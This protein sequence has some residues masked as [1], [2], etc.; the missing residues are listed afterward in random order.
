M[1]VFLQGIFIFLYYQHSSAESSIITVVLLL[2]LIP[3]CSL[4]LYCTKCRPV[5]SSRVYFSP[6]TFRNTSVVYMKFVI[7]IILL[8]PQ[9]PPSL[10][11]FLSTEYSR[12]ATIRITE[13]GASLLSYFRVLI[14]SFWN[15]SYKNM[16]RLRITFYGMLYSVQND[17]NSYSLT[18]FCSVCGN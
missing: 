18:A 17:Q 7:S 6:D 15:L 14:F 3:G 1:H 10:V 4:V 13:V 11:L 5:C 12:K 2:N 9:T 8:E 16:Q